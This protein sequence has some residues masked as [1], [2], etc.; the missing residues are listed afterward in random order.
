MHRSMHTIRILQCGRAIAA[1]AVVFHHAALGTE[2]RVEAL[3]QWLAVFFHFGFLG[4]DFFFV[5][6]GFI[7]LHAH[8]DDEQGPRAAIVYSKR[9][10]TRI[11]V[12]YLPIGLAMAAYYASVGLSFNL[13]TSLTLMPA[14]APALS[15]AWTLT[16]E[17]LFYSIFAVSYFTRHFAA[18]ASAWAVSIVGFSVLVGESCCAEYPAVVQESLRVILSPLNLEFIF[19]MV[20]AVAAR[21]MPSQL[22]SFALPIGAVGIVA[23]FFSLSDANPLALTRAW[24]GLSVA[25]VLVAAVWLEELGRIHTPAW[26]MLLGDASYAIYLVHNPLVAF[27]ARVVGGIGFPTSWSI[28]L[29]LCAALGIGGGIAYHVLVEKPALSLFRQSRRN[30]QR[31]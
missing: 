11:Y 18:L 24:F 30:I 2:L 23:F 1:C 12:P 31:G 4:V 26:L 20:A 14:G 13:I 28:S 10:L 5:L 25:F 17:L 16:H 9:R 3:P 15:V 22:W 21:R 27:V 8:A 7:I 19:G 6:S 29:A